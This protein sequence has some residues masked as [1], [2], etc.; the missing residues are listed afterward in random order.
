MILLPADGRRFLTT[1]PREPTMNTRTL[2]K[3]VLAVAAVLVVTLS[4]TALAQHHRGS[5][6]GGFGGPHGAFGG[7]PAGFA[8]CAAG[9][10]GGRMHGG[11]GGGM[12]HALVHDLDLTSEQREQIHTLF[13][14]QRESMGDQ[15]GVLRQVHRDLLKLALSDTYSAEGVTNVINASTAALTEAAQAH[16]RTLNAAYQLLT[17]EQRQQL[18]TNLAEMEEELTDRR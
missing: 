12:L 8:G 9:C 16:T 18:A 3:I 10:R 11:P 1:N 5:G 2:S 4:L 7:P 6:R 14:E 13:M 17:P 15:H